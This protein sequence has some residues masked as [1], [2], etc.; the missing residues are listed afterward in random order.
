MR[1]KNLKIIITGGAGFIGS[2]L[3]DKLIKNNYVSVYDNL[4]SGK[5][6]YLKTNLK[7]KNFKSTNKK[8]FNLFFISF[9]C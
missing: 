1:I 5:K 3:I 4:T 8:K 7:K 2:N 6:D 9:F